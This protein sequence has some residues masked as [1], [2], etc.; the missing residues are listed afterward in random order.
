M[1]PFSLLEIRQAVGGRALTPVP[2]DAALVTVVSTD[3]RNFP[4]GA[5]FFAIKG[6]NFDG[7]D[8]LAQ[9]AAAGAAAAVV[10]HAPPNP[11]P[12][13]H[14]IL[15]SDSRQAMGR[16]AAAVRKTL[17]GKVIAVGGSNGKT[18][19]KHLIHAALSAKLRGSMSPKSFN[20]D[21]G[22][23]L[24]IFP[25]QPSQDYV[26]LEMGTNHRGEIGVLTRMATPDIAVI[27]NC[28]VEHLAGLGDLAGVRLENATITEGLNEKGLLVVNGDDEELLAAV[29]GFRRRITFGYKPSNDLFPSD[30]E[31]TLA[32]VRFRLNKSK[33][34][35]SIPLLGKHTAVNALAAIAVA[36][37]IGVP[38]E[39]VVAGLANA[40]G[41]EMR[42][43]ASEHG[44]VTIINDA[45]NA[46]P[47]SMRAALETFA[48]LKPRT[49][50]IAVLGDMLELGDTSERYHREIGE[51]A[52]QSGLDMLICIGEQAALIAKSAKRLPADAIRT[53]S[54]SSSAAAEVANLIAVGDLVLLKGSR[55]MRLEKVADAVAAR[56]AMHAQ[57]A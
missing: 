20:N 57:S 6:E 26:V 25:C 24:A 41:P 9:A 52:N 37:R 44:G 40:T 10:Q 31:C 17:R 13:L 2:A 8:Y 53:Y 23:P 12:G 28:G 56:F 32:G 35:I 42:L 7:H 30:I 4:A 39:A 43:Q 15:V 50:R 11:I 5:L 19:T 22:V 18:G 54:D 29:S 36:R 3:T 16:L 48:L 1:K 38:E 33:L 45:Y 14:L 49:R 34:V 51:L 27:T 21:I 55:G 47:S 46:N